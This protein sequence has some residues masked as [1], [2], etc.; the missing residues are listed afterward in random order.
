MCYWLG[1]EVR[2]EESQ[3]VRRARKGNKGKRGQSPTLI[4]NHYLNSTFSAVEKQSFT[5]YN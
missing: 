2:G 1:T 4:R 5:N 3:V